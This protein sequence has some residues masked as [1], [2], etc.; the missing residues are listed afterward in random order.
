MSV[1]KK[2]AAYSAWLEREI[3]ILF[4]EKQENES[5]DFLELQRVQEKV[6]SGID[7]FGFVDLAILFCDFRLDSLGSFQ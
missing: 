3:E 4:T 2:G 1:L 5:R 6:S 7:R